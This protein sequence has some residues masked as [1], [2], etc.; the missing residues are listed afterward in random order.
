MGTGPLAGI[1]VVDVSG[2]VAGP[3]A[4]SQLAEQG[5]DVILVEKVGVPD[6]MRLTGAIVGDQSGTWVQMHRN[7]RAIDLDVRHP[8]GREILLSLTDDADVF[9]QNFRPGV[10][11][12]LGI[13]YADVSARNPDIVYLSV[14][15]YG[16][17]GPY[18]GEPVYDPIIQ[19]RSGMAEAQNGDY[20]RAVVADKTAAMTGANAILAALVARGNGQGGQHIEVNLLESMLAW[21]FVEAYWNETLPDADPTPTYSEWYMPWDTADGQIAANWTNFKQ[22]Q[23]ACRAVGRPDLADDPRFSSREGRLKNADAQRREFGEALA[24]MTTADALDALHQ[25]DVPAAPVLARHE[26]FDDPQ[27][28]HRGTIIESVHPTAGRTRTARPPA[29]FEKTPTAIERHAPGKGEHTDEILAQLGHDAD[30]I[31]RLR[32]DG[33]VD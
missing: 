33:V 9:I 11:D 22:Y 30:S 19:A 4:S 24:K 25:A 20:V 6:V 17:D 12:R 16:P 2:A 1:K 14:S 13:G 15:G 8:E 23:G 7:K 10:V 18:S 28:V 3:W 5:A 27:V 32:A 31:A 26:I 29:R 21:L